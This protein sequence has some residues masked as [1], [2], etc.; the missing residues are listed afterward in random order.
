MN[1]SNRSLLVLFNQEL[2]SPHAIEHEVGILNELLHHVENLENV[3]VSHEIIDL[4]RHKL[5]NDPLS[6]RKAFRQHKVKG[7]VFLNNKN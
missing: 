1:R 7:F 2:K 5:Y 6:L 3:M 4:N